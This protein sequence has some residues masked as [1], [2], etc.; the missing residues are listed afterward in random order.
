MGS[1]SRQAVQP[2]DSWK[3]GRMA[4]VPCTALW[5][6]AAGV[7]ANMGVHPDTTGLVVEGA[8]TAVTT[9]ATTVAA[10]AKGKEERAQSDGRLRGYTGP[11]LTYISACTC[12]TGSWITWCSST[13]P[14]GPST[15]SPW[16]TGTWLAGSL[17]A[18]L[19]YPW[20]RYSRRH[21]I[22]ADHAAR[23]QQETE[24][25]QE[26]H[27]EWEEIFHTAL[28]NRWVHE[29]SRIETPGGYLLRV[30]LPDDGRVTYDMVNTKL[31][32][33][34]TIA[35]RR[36]GLRSGALRMEHASN[37]GEF[38]FHVTERDVLAE[39]VPLP[40]DLSLIESNNPFDI[41]LHE[42]ATE[43]Y[44]DFLRH[45][46]II[47][48]T[49]SGKSNLLNVIIKK[50]GQMVD[51]LLWVIDPKGGRMVRPWLEPF[52]TGETN[53]PIIDWVAT[54]TG[55]REE[56]A[57]SPAEYYLLLDTALAEAERRSSLGLGGEKVTTSCD[58]PRIVVIIDECADVLK[59]PYLHQKCLDLVRKGRSEGIYLL[60]AGQRGTV[61]MM[62]SG[63]LKSQIGNTAGL[64]VRSAAD[65]SSVFPNNPEVSKMLPKL[66]HA[67][68]LAVQLGT[69]SRPVPGKTYRI[70]YEEIGGLA[71]AL[72]DRRPDLP[73]D[74]QRF[75]GPVYTERWTDKKRIQ[76]LFVT[77]SSQLVPNTKPAPPAAPTSGGSNPTRP[78]G[79]GSTA[80]R[81]GLPPSRIFG[82][83][84]WSKGEPSVYADNDPSLTRQGESIAA[85]AEAFLRNTPR[86]A[87]PTPPNPSTP[88][89]GES[90]DRAV[91]T[92]PRYL[93]ALKVLA[94]F[95]NGIG[96]TD[97]LAEMGRRGVDQPARQTLIRW[98]DE[99]PQVYK[100]T[101]YKFYVLRSAEQPSPAA[102]PPQVPAATADESYGLP[103]DLTLDDVLVAVELVVST[104][105]GST[106]M[107]QR[108]MRLG[109]A[110]T[111]ALM[112]LLEE[113]GIVG[114]IDGTK[115]R[116]V[117]VK[118]ED[119][120][121]TQDKVRQAL[122]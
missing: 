31:K 12:A 104:Q 50:G 88:G 76:H 99:T 42:D 30:E 14:W 68:T 120:A 57:R 37:D 24:P 43:M 84:G 6:A 53:R 111:E 110:V 32:T 55:R 81:L 7:I 56:G 95:P 15:A 77:D 66:Q 36:L 47:G 118:P 75:H 119:L 69:K 28:G 39:L 106:S 101:G 87:G 5:V 20:Y 113:L 121:A 115:A 80:R 46:M 107:L 54:N 105:F 35:G 61:T 11:Q 58:L 22:A 94:D 45:G 103:G 93:A 91:S 86:P 78:G 117:L 4:T 98:L 48:L 63:D 29:A 65:A 74:A 116:D 52:L 122:Q 85:E 23:H 72:A 67:G 8:V 114:E 102:I 3:L 90:A 108:K 112:K 62:G 60:L 38:L 18:W 100:P 109:F 49:D 33:I 79:I 9:A 82:G 1:R 25:D 40:D 97:L 44:W 26:V 59:D 17:A 96:V 89:S 71:V 21:E 73:L 10:V 2:D 27:T 51:T 19:L 41:G 13:L 70:E 34:S 83:G 64:G 16:V 92:D